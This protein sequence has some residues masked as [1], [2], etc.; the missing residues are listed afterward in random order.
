MHRSSRGINTGVGA[1]FFPIGGTLSHRYL[2][3]CPD[4]SHGWQSDVNGTT[5]YLT[6]TNDESLSS[7]SEV[8]GNIVD[9]ERS[10]IARNMNATRHFPPSDNPTFELTVVDVVRLT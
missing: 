10:L 3:I 2:R 9:S 4:E 5:C 8:R 6:A 7:C 1:A